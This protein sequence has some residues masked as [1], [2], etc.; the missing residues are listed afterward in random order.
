MA[1]VNLSVEVQNRGV[2]EAT[3]AIERLTASGRSAARVINDIKTATGTLNAAM[4]GTKV[5]LGTAKAAMGELQKHVGKLR[6][7][8]SALGSVMVGATASERLKNWGGTLDQGIARARLLK[9]Q[10]DA[11]NANP[12]RDLMAVEQARASRLV[13]QGNLEKARWDASLRGMTE[14]QR[15]TAQL[16]RAENEYAAAARAAAAAET[17][18]SAGGGRF[19]NKATGHWASAPTD[20]EIRA[21]AKATE[22]LARATTNLSV[23]QSKL[24]SLESRANTGLTSASS[25]LSEANWN[26]ELAGMGQ[27]EAAQARLTRATIEYAKAKRLVD[28]TTSAVSGNASVDNINR[29]AAAMNLLAEKT[30]ALSRAQQTQHHES[31]NAFQSSYSYFILAGLAQQATQALVGLGTAAVT[32]S[33]ETERAFADTRRT[34]EGTDAQLSRLQGRLR[35][36]STETPVSI[37][38]LTEIATLGNQLGIAANDIEKFT[39]VIAQYTAVSGVS[40]EDAAT[41]FGRISNLTGIA[42]SEYDKLASAITYTARTTVATESSI[43]STAKE[44]TAL[45]SGAGFSASAIVGLAGALSSLAIPPERARGALSL[46]FGALNT[47][48]SEGGPKLKA[49]AELTNMTTQELD[50]LVRSNQGEKVFTSFIKGL[51]DLDTVAKTDALKTLGLGT[52]RV[53]Q[54]MRALAQNVPLVTQSLDGAH[55]A[56]ASGTDI[57]NQYGIIQET[58]DSK[59]KRF[60][61][62]LFN[63]AAAAGENGG[64]VDSLKRALDAGTEFIVFLTEVSNTPAGKAFLTVATAAMLVVTALSAL[65]GALSLAKASMVVTAFALKGLDFGG[66]AAGIKIWAANLLGGSAAANGTA[67]ATTRLAASNM[68]YTGS[69]RVASASQTALNTSLVAGTATANGA[70]VA[71]RGLSAAMRIA[72]PILAITAAVAGINAVMDAADK[73]INPVK[74][75]GAGVDSLKQAI[76]D[77]NIALMAKGVD[78]VGTGASKADSK[79]SAFNQSILDAISVQKQAEDQ[80]GRTNDK[81]GEQEFKLGSSSNAWIENAL[82][83]SEAIQDLI[84]GRSTWDNIRNLGMSPKMIADLNPGALAN[85]MLKSTDVLDT[86]EFEAL[87]ANG[88]PLAELSKVAAEKGSEVAKEQYKAWAS[89]LA[90][91]KP[92]LADAADRF[93]LG[94]LPNLLAGVEDGVRK[95]RMEAALA[96]SSISATGEVAASSAGNLADLR[97]AAAT[98][99]ETS[100]FAFEGA[101]DRLDDFRKAISGAMQEYVGFSAVTSRAGELLKKISD[102]D[103]AAF[104]DGSVL[105]SIEIEAWGQSL[106]AA[107][108][109]ANTFYNNIT[110]LAATGSQAL[111]LGFAEMGPEAAGLIAGALELGPEELANLEVSARMAGFLASDAYLDSLRVN[112]ASSE[113]AYSAIFDET[114]S[115]DKVREYIAAQVAGTGAEWERQW[116]INHPDMP[117]NVTPEL[118]DLPPEQLKLWGDMQNGKIQV[119]ATVKPGTSSLSDALA[120]D[121]DWVQYLDSATGAT[122]TL[123]ANLDDATLTAS[124]MIW[125]A[126]QSATPAE[127]A[128]KLQEAGLSSSL[129]AWVSSQPDINLRAAVTPYLTKSNFEVFVDTVIRKPAGGYT[130]GLIDKQRYG[131][132]KFPRFA[133]GGGYKV[134]GP[135]SG[136]SDSI[137]ARLSA[138]E[139][140]NTKKSVD[141]WGADFFDSLNRRMLPASM[142]KL[143]G[144]AMVSGN[145]SSGNTT[146]VSIVQQNPVTRDPLKQLREDSER[147]AAGIWG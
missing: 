65:V 88:L 103:D 53:D 43:Q 69:T 78:G 79:V 2:Q 76:M 56:Y 94:V 44:I 15:A 141:F 81:L 93:G 19:R 39:Q 30:T 129:G 112:M 135:G 147:V 33:R 111:A 29:Q 125:R 96:K 127:L 45:A 73:A 32:A 126:N 64:L 121:G 62:A 41:A 66:S 84:K 57:M 47:A 49:F 42:A 106:T 77:D 68:A 31:D 137:L 18:I 48:V 100:A 22:E 8:Y 109:D 9:Q 116:A 133:T 83:D 14:A 20:A 23:A 35:E 140:V 55:N 54:T 91:E 87:L 11:L 124:L 50:S 108:A 120:T 119:K 13:A 21:E 17:A 115:L 70:S 89:G 122:I 4:S 138:G 143:F 117:L 72:W 98:A 12:V 34:F 99:G 142:M 90:K 80:L 7:E 113:K 95:A 6:E 26:R 27:V 37:I 82:K 101:T 132:D 104:G 52:I 105:P 5:A 25:K 139:Y 85:G 46:Y 63:A 58:L 136:I 1:D 145:Q 40:A 59:M 123:P 97:D 67:A 3:A 134:T 24:R 16:T 107:T 61:N 86:K 102:N 131:D 118:S 10:M 114:K 28:A 92:D 51:S 74:N 60:Q 38:D 36:L 130:G 146:N 110:Q 128:A 75:L 71:M 144:A